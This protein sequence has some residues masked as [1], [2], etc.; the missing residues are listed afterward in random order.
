LRFIFSSNG[1][2]NAARERELR[3]ERLNTLGGI[4]RARAEDGV[5]TRLEEVRG[6][7]EKASSRAARY[8]FEVDALSELRKH[9]EAA[10]KEARDAYF[11]PVKKEI[12]PLLSMLHDDAG[13]EMD[14]DT[15]LP[16]KIVRDGVAE[17]IDTLSGGAAEQIAILTR[18]AFARLYAQSGK[19]VPVILD[20]A[21][22]YSDD[23]RIVKMFTALTRSAK[24]QQIIVLSCRTRA[25]EE[26]GGTRAHI[27][28]N[29]AMI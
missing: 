26:L 11:E 16:A 15:M 22:V 5:E 25:F 7:I 23:D 6:Q 21:L 19:K 29:K 3:L 27:E 4:I 14:P 28:I 13:I 8:K 12:G 20:D 9:L 1:R 10:R 2:E 18:L 24:D 17:E